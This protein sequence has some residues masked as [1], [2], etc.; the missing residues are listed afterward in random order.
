[1]PKLPRISSREAIRALEHLGF[2]VVRQTGSHIVMK[3]TTFRGNCPQPL[4]IFNFYIDLTCSSSKTVA[5]FETD[6]NHTPNHA[7]A[8][9]TRRK[10]PTTLLLPRT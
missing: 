1:M 2:E 9:G 3:Q 4:P 5:R 8:T 6:S 7:V 10:N